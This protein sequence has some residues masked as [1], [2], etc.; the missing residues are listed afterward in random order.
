V[1]G[2]EL[3]IENAEEALKKTAMT[4]DVQIKDYSVGPVFME[5]KDKGAHEWIIEFKSPP[6][7]LEAFGQTLDDNLREVNSDYDAKRNHDLTLKRL[8]LHSAKSGLFYAWLKSNEKLGGQHKIPRLSNER[9]YIDEL[10]ELQSK[11]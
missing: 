6:E 11:L 8:K 5:G 7:S 2:E 1:F 9:N 10:L 4:F 3:I